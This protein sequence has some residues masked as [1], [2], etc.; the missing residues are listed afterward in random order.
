LAAQIVNVVEEEVDTEDM[1]DMEEEEEKETI[2]S[3]P[4]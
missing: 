2:A 1:E 4:K 3:F